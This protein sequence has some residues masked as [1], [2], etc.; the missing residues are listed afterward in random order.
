MGVHGRHAVGGLRRVWSGA[1]EAS[2][3]DPRVFASRSRPE[4]ASHIRLV[5][6]IR[7]W[8]LSRL[9]T[10]GLRGTMPLSA[11]GNERVTLSRVQGGL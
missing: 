9:I 11:E 1:A 3:T 8:L 7:T 6:N 2:L 10:V 4:V 5:L